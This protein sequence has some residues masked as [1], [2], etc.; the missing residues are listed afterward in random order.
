MQYHIIFVLTVDITST[1]T[2]FPGLHEDLQN[3]D[4]LTLTLMKTTGKQ[5]M[6]AQAEI[7]DSI[8]V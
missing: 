8:I 6:I 5:L 4:F 3:D 7:G 2:L 1:T